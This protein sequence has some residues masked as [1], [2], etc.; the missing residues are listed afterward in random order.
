MNMKALNGL[1][2]APPDRTVIAWVRRVQHGEAVG[3]LLPI[4]IAAVDDDAADGGTVPTDVLRRRMHDDGRAVIERPA[5]DRRGGIVHDQ[6]H[7]ERAADLR[8][9]GD[10]KDGE[11][12][13][14]QGFGVVAARARIGGAAEV[15]RIGRVDEAHLHAHGLHGIEEEIPGAAV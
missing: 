12:R 8:H 10:G 11:L 14:G 1:I 6:R 3:V 13:I 4:E 2:A 15:L 5:K 9:L 7:A